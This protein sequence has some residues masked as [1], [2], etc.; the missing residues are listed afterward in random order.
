MKPVRTYGIAAIA[1]AA[2]LFLPLHALTANPARDLGRAF[3]DA[4]EKAMPGVVVIRT[5]SVYFDRDYHWIWGH[6]RIP[7]AL[8]GQ[9]S[10]VIIDRDGFVLTNNHVIDDADE[11]EVVLHD[12]TKYD[13][14]I[15][16]RYPM[17][18]LAVLKI[19]NSDDH[20]F[21]PV[22]LGD[23]ESIRVGEFVIAIGSPFSLDG[24]VTIGNISHKK[25][26][27]DL[28]PHVEFIQTDAAINPGNSGGALIDVDGKLVG[29]NTMIQTGSPLDQSSSGVGFAIPVNHAISVAESLKSGKPV[30]RAWIGIAPREFLRPGVGLYVA[31]V[32]EGTP[33]DKGGLKE[34][35][36]ITEVEGRKVTSIVGL[37]RA[38]F[39][40]AIGDTVS[41]TIVRDDETLRLELVT[42]SMPAMNRF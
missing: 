2:S 27:S 1:L 40:K 13:A 18:D 12:G 33:A 9:A 38:V 26:G 14:E 3:A 30:Q 39:N 28:V 20:A 17:S 15:V 35:D 36:I 11:I 24:T 23:S 5:K 34:G 4:V 37:Q 41:M 22:E 21:T 29:I 8:A 6:I 42:E 31:Q 10:G 16:G 25:R 32:F 7:R 19:V